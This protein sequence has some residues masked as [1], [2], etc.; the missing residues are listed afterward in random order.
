LAE[1]A[2]RAAFTGIGKK[3]V[4]ATINLGEAATFRLSGVDSR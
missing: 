4:V 2:L 3:I 1:R